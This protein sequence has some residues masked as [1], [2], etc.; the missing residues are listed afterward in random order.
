[1]K[2]VLL[3]GATGFVGCHFL[4]SLAEKGFEVHT[5]SRSPLDADLENSNK[6]DVHR[7]QADLLDLKQ[8]AELIEKIRPTH[9]IH[10]AWQIEHGRHWMAKEN[11]Q[12]VNA[13]VA[14]FEQFIARGGQRA[15]CA[16]TCFEYAL[17][18]EIYS[19]D[20]TPIKPQTVYGKCKAALQLL[21]A[22][23]AQKEDISVAWGRLFFTYGTHDRSNRLIPYVIRALLEN[24]PALCSHGSQIRDFLYI[25]DVADA[26]V[27]LLDS[28]VTGEVNIAS[29]VPVT[30][31]EIILKAAEMTG[32]RDLVKFGAID[33]APNEPP[34]IVADVGRLQREVGW[35]PKWSLDAG[36]AKTVEWW[37]EDV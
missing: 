22:A 34:Q 10:L 37:R 16:G 6:I 8:T 4:P 25:E 2:R 26:F 27:S 5:V 20:E 30:L 3:T 21:L 24:E 35:Q 7:H 9:L 28:E 33:A 19:E 36:L 1:M 18:D 29:G 15:V 13:S 11:F 14:L 32:N 23:L 31:K 12:W 17:T